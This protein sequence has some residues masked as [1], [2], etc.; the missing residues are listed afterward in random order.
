MRRI[1]SDP[2][3]LTDRQL[4]RVVAYYVPIG[5]Q[6]AR[7]PDLHVYAGEFDYCWLADWLERD[8]RRGTPFLAERE[9]RD[10]DRAR[11]QAADR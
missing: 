1:R 11:D 4:Q 9:R 7:M 3:L 5:S 10:R 8:V 2:R 6:L